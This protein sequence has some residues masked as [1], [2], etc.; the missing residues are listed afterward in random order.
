MWG[1]GKEGAYIISA[2]IISEMGNKWVD[3]FNINHKFIAAE[4]FKMIMEF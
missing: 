4:R 1:W 3:E 2:G